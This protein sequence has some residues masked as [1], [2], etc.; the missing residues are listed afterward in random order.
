MDAISECFEISNL[1]NS[2]AAVYHILQCTVFGIL[3]LCIVVAKIYASPLFSFISA[4]LSKPLFTRNWEVHIKFK[5][6]GQGTR[7]FGDGWAFWY[8]R[9]RSHLGEFIFIFAPLAYISL[10]VTSFQI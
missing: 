2:A 10:G 8:T 4:S 6:H 7:L 3:I 9:D 5:V 1:G